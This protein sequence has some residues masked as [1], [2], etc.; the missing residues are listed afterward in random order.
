VIRGVSPSQELP[1][2][3]SDIF[4]LTIVVYTTIIAP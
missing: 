2:G 4:L 3:D 1:I